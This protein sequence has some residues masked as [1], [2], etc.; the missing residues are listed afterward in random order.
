MTSRAMFLVCGV[1]GAAVMAVA[2]GGAA[3]PAVVPGAAGK[4][5]FSDAP[6]YASS[7]VAT[8]AA[9]AHAAKKLPAPSKE[10]AC[11]SCHK[12]GGTAPSFVFAGTM[13][14]DDTGKGGLGDAEI[15]FV[16]DKGAGSSAHSDADGNF[17]LKGPSAMA[18][19][20]KAAARKGAIVKLMEP[21]VSGNCNECH[22]ANMPMF[23]K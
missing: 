12:T 15:R 19:T 5:V 8:T 7:P 6:A 9:A 20:A 2:C 4:T 14:T 22:A 23:V 18:D 10:T 1:V 3:T 16:D 13:Y 21:A 11:L 17:W